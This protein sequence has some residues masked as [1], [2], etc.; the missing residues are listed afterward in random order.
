M[1]DTRSS[2]RMIYSL[3][4]KNCISLHWGAKPTSGS[5]ALI[6]R[7]IWGSGSTR[8]HHQTVSDY[9]LRQLHPT[10][11]IS[12]HSTIPVPDSL[13]RR[14]ETLLSPYVFDTSLSSPMM[15]NLQSYATAVLKER[16]CQFT[17]IKTYSSLTRRAAEERTHITILRRHPTLTGCPS[18]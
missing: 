6:C 16:M 17:G 2:R 7:K 9:T 18:K 1:C 15:W 10:S 4:S 8:S 5:V 11:I 3:L 13:Y 14:L 12:T